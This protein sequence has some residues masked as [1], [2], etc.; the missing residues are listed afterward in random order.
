MLEEELVS[1]GGN[2]TVGDIDEERVQRIVDITTPIFTDA[3]TAPAAGL[4]ATDLFTNEF[5]DE[6]IGP[7]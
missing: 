7:A 4:V 1:N 5:L 2:G 6:S 3:G